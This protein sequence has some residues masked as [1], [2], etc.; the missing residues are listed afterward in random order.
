LRARPAWRE[1]DEPRTT[2][3]LDYASWLATSA[4]TLSPPVALLD[5][6]DSSV[7][8]TAR[9]VCGWLARVMS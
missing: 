1:W 6:T 7:D 8:A 4:A 9:D 2:E 3:M 5:T